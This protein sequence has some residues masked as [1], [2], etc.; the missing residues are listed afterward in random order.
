MAQVFVL[1]DRHY[2][3]LRV[4]HGM[5]CALLAIVGALGM[6]HDRADVRDWFLFR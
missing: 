5:V 3:P 4:H 6:W 1:R 2:R